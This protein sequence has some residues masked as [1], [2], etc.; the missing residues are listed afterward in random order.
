MKTD[1]DVVVIGAGPAGTAAAWQLART[2]FRTLLLDKAAFPRVKP[3]GGGVTI[4]ALALLPY[5][6]GSVIERVK[7]HSGSVTLR[8]NPATLTTQT[9]STPAVASMRPW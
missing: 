2:G 9:M 1:Y 7:L 3:C 8:N 6:V 4:K 5:S